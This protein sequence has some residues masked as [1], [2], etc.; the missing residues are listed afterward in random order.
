[1][2]SGEDIVYWLQRVAKRLGRP[3]AAAEWRGRRA[4]LHATTGEFLDNG[5]PYLSA[6]L[7]HFGS[8]NVALEAAGLPTR[9]WGHQGRWWTDEEM[10]DLL[11][12]DAECLGH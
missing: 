4:T 12:Q 9:V 11:R 8:W 2:W 6:I 3:P 7:R 1:M 5:V 10:L